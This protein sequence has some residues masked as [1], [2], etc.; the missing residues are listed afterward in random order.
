MTSPTETIDD[1]VSKQIYA[2]KAVA[3]LSVLYAHMPMK[4]YY[5]IIQSRIGVIGVVVFFFLSGYLFRRKPS[6]LLWRR[7]GRTII[8]PWLVG[9]S[10]T[11]LLHCVDDGIPLSFQNWLLWIIG[12]RTLYYYIPMLLFCY[13][14]FNCFDV[15]ASFCLFMTAMGFVS[16]TLTGFGIID[17]YDYTSFT[18]NYLNPLNWCGYF[19]LGRYMRIRNGF[20]MLSDNRTICMLSLLVLVVLILFPIEVR[21]EYWTMYGI[22]IAFV[23][24]PATYLFCSS[25]LV[26]MK[27]VRWIG[28]QTL[29]I[30]LYH[31]QIA[32]KIAAIVSTY[33]CLCLIA[34]LALL[35]LFGYMAEVLARLSSGR[36]GEH[37]IALLG[38]NRKA[39]SISVNR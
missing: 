16:L 33:G 36:F 38:I 20:R 26:N 27:F 21:C 14:L 10:L 28:A 35:L 32:G 9:A 8:L 3:I 5:G 6:K 2:M 12:S 23:C 4:G 25:S 1:A 13:A 18:T 17:F 37:L 39:L 11:F 34:P 30:Y 24:I 31:I 29:F 15:S 7:K 19:A 22:A